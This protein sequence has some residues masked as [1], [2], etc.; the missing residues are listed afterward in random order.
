ME[1]QTEV[2]KNIA[3]QVKKFNLYALPQFLWL[4]IL[5][6]LMI[7]VFFQY[8]Q[9][10]F[11]EDV[12]I[13]FKVINFNNLIIDTIDKWLPF[14]WLLGI[15]FFL[16]GILISLIKFF[17]Y[18]DSYKVSDHGDYGIFLGVWISLIAFACTLYNKLGLYFPIMVPLVPTIKYIWDKTIKKSNKKYFD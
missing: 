5:Y 12:S 18:I 2:V 10:L 8:F 4:A 7:N 6:Y 16:S 11:K 14:T 15:A 13:P 17:P 3:N 1:L 9:I